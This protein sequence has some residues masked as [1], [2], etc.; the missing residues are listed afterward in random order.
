[1]A[2]VAASRL[3][4]LTPVPAR[5]LTA[6]HFASVLPWHLSDSCALTPISAHW[7]RVRSHSQLLAHRHALLTP[8]LTSAL[9]CRRIEAQQCPEDANAG[10]PPA[11]ADASGSAHA[12]YY[13]AYPQEA[14]PGYQHAYAPPQNSHADGYSGD[15]GAYDQGDGG[16][17]SGYPQDVNGE[18][19]GWD[20]NQ[21]GYAGH[22]VE[23]GEPYGH[24]PTQ[25][26]AQRHY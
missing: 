24:D 23:H 5:V 12:G 20:P 8:S 25:W 26:Q 4:N 10:A 1:M 2:R 22:G 3:S 19:Y 6:V 18:A 17:H 13:E 16:A 15:Y 21:A 9:A 14:A 7:A 11:F